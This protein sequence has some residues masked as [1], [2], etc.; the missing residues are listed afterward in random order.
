MTPSVPKENSVQ[1]EPLLLSKKFILM[2]L[3]IAGFQCT[4]PDWKFNV[5]SFGTCVVMFVTTL[6]LV[7]SLIISKDIFQTLETICCIGP[8]VPVSDIYIS[9]LTVKLETIF[10]EYIQTV[11]GSDIANA[12]SS[13]WDFIEM[14]NRGNFEGR[15]LSVLYESAH[16][17]LLLIKI[18]VGSYFIA[19]AVYWI[20]P[21]NELFF[22]HKKTLLVQFFI[23]FLDTQYT[24][25]YVLTMLSQ[26]T[27]AV[28]GLC[29]STSFDLL[30]AIFVANYQGVVSI[31]ECQLQELVEINRR[32]NT[33]RNR[34][35][36][37]AFLWNIYIQLLD[38]IE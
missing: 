2:L 20:Y 6:S 29:G 21:L 26:A 38:M 18:F 31:W 33:L 1:M 27:M 34:S 9:K 24:W 30:L 4:E 35:Y 8:I 22:Q 32:P 3:Y 25:G 17:T 10:T 23:P 28:Y 11:F 36:R 16:H 12:A 15:R 5:R 37:R 14:V 13:L 19:F 7:Y